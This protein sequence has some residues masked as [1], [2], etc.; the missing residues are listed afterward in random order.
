MKIKNYK[1][2]NIII[3]SKALD[4]KLVWADYTSIQGFFHLVIEIIL[5]IVC[6]MHLTIK[7][8][9]ETKKE[10]KKPC[11]TSRHR[12]KFYKAEQHWI[13]QVCVVKN[14]LINFWFSM[15]FPQIVKI[16]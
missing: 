13:L 16:S 9:N 2:Y 11:M 15:C 10:D 5:N 3:T 4:Q 8:D 14:L 1:I 7:Y 6:N 12:G